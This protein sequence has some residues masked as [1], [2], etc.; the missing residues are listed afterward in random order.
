[1][2]L[3]DVTSLDL[4]NQVRM[5]C[6][7]MLKLVRG[8]RAQYCMKE[9]VLSLTCVVVVGAVVRAVAGAVALAVVAAVVGAVEEVVVVFHW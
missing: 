2:Y 5:V 9:I 8:W 6:Y 3:G 4:C 7:L 1:M